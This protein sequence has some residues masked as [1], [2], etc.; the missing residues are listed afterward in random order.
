MVRILANGFCGRA[1]KERKVVAISVESEEAIFCFSPRLVFWNWIMEVFAGG[2][3]YF[4]EWKE[5]NQ[6]NCNIFVS[7]MF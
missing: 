1:V 7:L 3:R 2:F 6:L 5:T 4:R